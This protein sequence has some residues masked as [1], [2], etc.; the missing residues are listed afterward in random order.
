MN[1]VNTIAETG[2]NVYATTYTTPSYTAT[3]DMNI[4]LR[5]VLT[6]WTSGVSGN[7][8][9]VRVTIGGTEYTSDSRGFN[10]LTTLLF[11]TLTGNTILGSHMFPIKNGE[12]I[13]FGV[14]S[15]NAADVSVNYSIEIWEDDAVTVAN[16][17]T[18][19][20]AALLDLISS[21]AVPG[22]AMTL[23]SAYDAAK[24]AATAAQVWEYVTRTLTSGGGVTAE[25]IWNYANRTITQVSAVSA[26][27]LV[28]YNPAD[29][30]VI[31]FAYCTLDELV[32]DL[33]LSTANDDILE[34][35]IIPATQ[36][37]LREI[38]PFI[39][40]YEQKLLQGSGGTRM[41]V[42]PLTT[43]VAISNDGVE[44]SAS[45]YQ[46][47]PSDRMWMYGPYIKIDCDLDTS[48]VAVWDSARDG[49]QLTAAFSLWEQTAKTGATL[50]VTLDNDDETL[51]ASDGSK[52]SPGAVLLLD[53]EMLFVTGSD[54][55]SA[56][57]TSLA[58]DCAA[59]DNVLT[60]ASAA[61]INIGEVIRV[62]FEDFKVLRKS[63]NRLNVVPGWN[64][65]TK[66]AHTSSADVDV[67]RAF[68]VERAING[69][70]AGGHTSGAVI[71]RYKTPEDIN[72]LTR[73]IAALMLKKSQTGY[74]GRSGNADGETFYNFEFPR[75]AI[76]RIKR[77]YYI[78]RVG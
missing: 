10:G 60:V 43:I 40:V 15:V 20:R 32:R 34:R 37:V 67:Y 68:R 27:A 63:G 2:K 18:N 46:L 62:D 22:D 26:G 52:L 9:T 58:A 29:S 77:N 51:V 54:E 71:K 28:V 4:R 66:S 64:N 19:A 6:G 39:P 25:D 11:N 33:E 5:I 1:L 13:R 74:A 45:D 17:W 70:S 76:E 8:I 57:V 14:R 69:T 21:R 16:G 42:P 65:T 49:V 7:F 30:A 12:S 73:Q 48:T 31:R 61:S 44:L 36:Y 59:G 38:G 78:P 23:T 24:L 55:P 75:D 56:A 41:S 3:R 72:Y 50:A 53:S 47:G 35:F